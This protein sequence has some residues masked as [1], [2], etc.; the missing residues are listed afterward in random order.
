MYGAGVEYAL[1]TMVNIGLQGGRPATSRALAAFQELPLAYVRKLLAGLG[2][3]GLLTGAEGA[4]GGWSFARPAE[5]ITVLDVADAV[6]PEATLFECREVRAGCV[7]WAG[8]EAPAAARSGTCSIHQVMLDAEAAA[9]AAIA[10]TTIADLIEAVRSKS[11][12]AHL[13][14][15]TGWFGEQRVELGRRTV[16]GR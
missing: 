11:S 3:A 12:T 10:R 13:E 9:R 2:R 15:L 14:R 7:L 1:H 8:S 4:A 16:G 5:S 6:H